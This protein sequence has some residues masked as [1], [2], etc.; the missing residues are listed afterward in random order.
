MKSE[1]LEFDLL[2]FIPF[3][4]FLAFFRKWNTHKD[5]FFLQFG[6]YPLSEIK[7]SNILHYLFSA[8]TA[9]SKRIII[10]KTTLEQN[11]DCP[12]IY[13]WLKYDKKN[14]PQLQ[15]SIHIYRCLLS[16]KEQRKR[17]FNSITNS[18]P[19]LCCLLFLQFVIKTYFSYSI[20]LLQL[21]SSFCSF[22][23]DQKCFINI[24]AT[25]VFSYNIISMSYNVHAHSSS[26]R[27]SFFQYI[28]SIIYMYIHTYKP[29]IG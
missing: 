27:S 13:T 26:L 17:C 9:T 10:K 14:K 3:M 23:F 24:N 29:L 19:F 5:P 22:A 1:T 7:I 18:S 25:K 2:A 20:R 6:T 11:H 15:F 4:N 16:S 12:Q 28:H 8:L 21:F